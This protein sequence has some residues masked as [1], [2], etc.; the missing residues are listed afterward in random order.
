MST[1][2]W[3]QFSAPLEMAPITAFGAFIITVHT[4]LESG[5][6]KTNCFVLS[7][8]FNLLN[9]RLSLDFKFPIRKLLTPPKSAVAIYIVG[10]LIPK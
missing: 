10:M 9:V 1:A 8:T 5:A 4:T 2:F 6:T 7:T 3:Q